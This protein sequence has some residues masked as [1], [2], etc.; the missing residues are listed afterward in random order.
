LKIDRK[1]GNNGKGYKLLLKSIKLFAQ[2][3]KQYKLL[4]YMSKSKP[5]LHTP[6][7]AKSPRYE[8][9][10]TFKAF[11]TVIQFKIT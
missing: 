4:R 6:R 5:R 2:L 1:G 7:L 3:Q 9:K 11:E 10:Y 8:L